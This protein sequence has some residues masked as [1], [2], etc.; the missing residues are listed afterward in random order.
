MAYFLTRTTVLAALSSLERQ[1]E[2]ETL[3]RGNRLYWQRVDSQ[4]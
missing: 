1:G 2:V 3:V 4:A